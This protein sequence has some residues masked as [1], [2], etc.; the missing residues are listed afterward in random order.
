MMQFFV[1][2]RLLCLVAL[3]TTLSACSHAPYAIQA[4][5]NPAAQKDKQV[6]LTQHG[7]H[8][9]LIVAADAITP[10]IPDLQ[11]RFP[12]AKFLRFGWGDNIVYQAD[13]TTF[14]ASTYAILLP[15]D[16]VMHVVATQTPPTVAFAHHKLKQLCLTE[17][18]H[19][20]TL[21]FISQSFTRNAGHIQP[22]QVKTQT[23]DQFYHA[24]G[25]YYFLN[26][27][28]TWTAKGLA[29]AGFD[30]YPL[31]NPA[32]GN[33]MRYLEQHTPTPCKPQ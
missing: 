3:I 21:T 2:F 13:D 5:G 15:T 9:G 20:A 12:D 8:T 29:S 32:A 18:E 33:V 23:N 19:Q 28:N 26:T 10:H 7:W 22:T 31:F 16:A 17:E 27:C 1:R 11:Q 4:S 25:T 30:I 6:Y 14:W 24:D